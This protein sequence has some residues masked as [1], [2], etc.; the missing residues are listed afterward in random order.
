M[1]SIIKYNLKKQV[2]HI[3]LYIFSKSEKKFHRIC[4]TLLDKKIP[5]QY[6]AFYQTKIIYC[7]TPVASPPIARI[8]KQVQTY[9]KHMVIIFNICF[10]FISTLNQTLKSARLK[11]LE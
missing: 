6:F 10:I 1:P 8:L 2:G 9:E 3:Y 11:T 5:Y 7:Y 4:S